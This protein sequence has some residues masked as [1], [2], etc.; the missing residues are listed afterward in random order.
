MDYGSTSVRFPS[1]DE[2][3]A[4]VTIFDARGR[5][6]RIVTAAEFRAAHPRATA[7][8]P[9]GAAAPPRRGQAKSA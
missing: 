7:T 5:V 3:V 4:P 2:S 1:D 6:V 8:R 9:F